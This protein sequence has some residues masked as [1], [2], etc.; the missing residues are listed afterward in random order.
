MKK[1]KSYKVLHLTTHLG[2]GVGSA[3]W[4]YLFKSKK[5]T[6]FTHKVV[7]LNYVERTSFKKAKSLGVE[8]LD[9]MNKKREDILKMIAETDLVLIHW[10]NH[11][12]LYDFLVREKLPACRVAIWS[13]VSGLQAPNVF[14]NKIL[15]YPDKFVFT[16]PISLESPVVK[17]ISS[18]KSVIW[19][20]GGVE[21][22]A[23][24]RSKKH[25]GFNI[26]YIG[27]IDYV[28]L[29]PNFLDICSKIDLPDVH[30][31]VCGDDNGKKL[32]DEAK[33]M[34][35]DNKFDFVG[36]VSDVP[37]YLSNFDLFGYPLSSS[38]YGTCDHALQ[39]S[40][41]AG[42]VPI[43]LGNKMEKSMV[44]DGVTGI[45]ANTEAEYVKA[46][47][48]LY[49]NIKLRKTLSNNARRYALCNFSTDKMAN[50][51]NIV[52]K[53]MLKMSKTP[54]KWSIRKKGKILSKDVFLESIGDQ[55]KVFSKY[56]NAKT[57]KEKSKTL[58]DIMSLGQLVN[59][60]AETKGTV[61]N[62][63]TFLSGDK[64]LALWSGL[65]KQG[66]KSKH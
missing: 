13:H 56:C 47:H 60:A 16:T 58:K 51:W 11:P 61:H 37:K 36:W 38:H 26:G 63:N 19:S 3:V 62:Y 52:F 40:M 48:R 24:L 54:K 53:E 44:K 5:D 29:Y 8:V 21:H 6:T 34:G 49:K 33:K 22:L 55:S 66:A 30:F 2:G 41:A 25:Y 12:L 43:V 20:T 31:I 50:D 10:W 17:K 35:I 65:M 45:V 42:V 57:K 1:I 18:D 15:R 23:S 64:H 32:K 39:E 59:W 28:K 9:M 46:V 7:C 27:T 4:G 14:T